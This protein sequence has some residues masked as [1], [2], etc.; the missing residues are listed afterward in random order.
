MFSK[1]MEFHLS[2]KIPVF[3]LAHGIIEQENECSIEEIVKTIDELSEYERE[4]K[5]IKQQIINTTYLKIVSNLL[6]PV[7]EYFEE[8]YE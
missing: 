7:N 2:R 5:E 4:I 3:I 8:E 1:I 6:E